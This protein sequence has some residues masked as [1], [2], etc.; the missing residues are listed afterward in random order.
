MKMEFERLA[1]LPHCHL[2]SSERASQAGEEVGES[3]G[4]STGLGGRKAKR[5]PGGREGH[6]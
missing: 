3:R 5:G 4:E 6:Q 2:G 1:E